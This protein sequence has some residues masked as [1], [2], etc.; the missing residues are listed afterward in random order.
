MRPILSAM[1]PEKLQPVCD[2]GIVMTKEQKAIHFLTMQHIQ[3][4]SR[5]L[6][7]VAIKILER[8]KIHDNS[9]LLSPEMEMFAEATPRLAGLTYGSDEY[10]KELKKLGVALEHHYQENSH[11][12]EHYTYQIFDM[13]FLDLIEMLCDWCAAVERHKDGNIWRS[14][15]INRD[16]YGMS[17]QLV[18]IFVNTLKAF[19][20]KDDAADNGKGEKHA[21]RPE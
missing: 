7:D 6:T 18:K 5:R 20:Y 11:H 17:D 8:A 1:R 19:G 15:E 10:R 9:K 4:V 12:P 14:L 2:G 16:R 13:D 3:N 21:H